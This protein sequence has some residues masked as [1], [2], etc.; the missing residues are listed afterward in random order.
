[1][2]Q[3]TA[4]NVGVR[5]TIVKTDHVQNGYAV[6]HQLEV[7]YVL[8]NGESRGTLFWNLSY[9]EKTLNLVFKT[10]NCVGWCPKAHSLIEIRIPFLHVLDTPLDND[11]RLWYIDD[12]ANIFFCCH[13]PWTSR[14]LGFKETIV[15]S[16]HTR[17]D[18]QLW[19]V[20]V[21]SWPRGIVP[22]LR[23]QT[24]RAWISHPVSGG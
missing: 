7:Y 20:G 3:T 22:D 17:K 1:M 5:W 10:Q 4:Y 24:A 12:F 8:K 23:P 13:H 9:P 18:S 19:R 11:Y 16:P 6:V 2:T 14:H 21:V 15:S